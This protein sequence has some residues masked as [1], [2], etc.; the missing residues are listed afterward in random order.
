MDLT[1]TFLNTFTGN[2]ELSLKTATKSANNSNVN[3]F[4]NYLSK[5]EEKNTNTVKTSESSKYSKA[6]SN[7]TSD[8]VGN[9]NS[10]NDKKVNQNKANDNNKNEDVKNQNAENIAVKT[11][12]T[13]S[14]KK[15]DEKELTEV[16]VKD[17]NQEIID[18]I[19]EKTGLSVEEIS[20]VLE[21]LNM[22]AVDLNDSNNLLN[23]MMK[24]TDVDSPMDLIS[25]DGV[26]DI[27]TEIK[28][29]F[30]QS[31][32]L[33]KFAEMLSTINKAEEV[34][35]NAEI[36]T[37]VEEKTANDVEIVNEDTLKISNEEKE[38]IVT[39][40]N[41]TVEV[42]TLENENVDDALT[43]INDEKIFS[44]QK[45]NEVSET[46]IVNNQAELNNDKVVVEVN[47]GNTSFNNSQQ[48]FSL[49]SEK[50]NQVNV[51]GV[52]MDNITKAFN[53]AVIRTEGAKHV[54]TAEVVKQ[55]ID[56]VKVGINKDVTELKISLK[57]EE[58]GDVTLKIAS[59]NGIVTA[60]ITAESQRVKEIIEAGF[61]QL[62]QALSEAGVEVS[63]LE[64]NVGSSDQN[65]Q[66]DN[67]N[68]S[69]EKSSARIN[70]IIAETEEEEQQVYIKE[71]EVVGS[72][73]NYTA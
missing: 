39:E 69:S 14:P 43:Q 3:N 2:S 24:L 42:A 53:E 18:L 30:T 62:K 46:K 1:K 66:Y 26:K 56:K 45:N 28:E 22:Q 20:R 36:D 64:V 23:F 55:I 68:S 63:Q 47:E 9:N 49:G 72:N 51:S 35:S 50:N 4:E 37:E 8:K 5:A 54:D 57:P 44:K 70:Q 25:V 17:I 40:E 32:D 73:V 48:Q 52:V 13:D 33:T 29:V 16:E 31:E 7:V 15:V 58:L 12:D 34:V 11:Q 6:D 41:A 59:Q 19:S 21:S 10:N 71:N 61:N 38:T 67:Q 60:Q 27:M 65:S